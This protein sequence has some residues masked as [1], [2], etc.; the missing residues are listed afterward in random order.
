MRRL[1]GLLAGAAFALSAVVAGAASA[2][3]GPDP[4]GQPA[5][6]SEASFMGDATPTETAAR[7]RDLLQLRP[8]QE[9]ALQTFVAALNSAGQ[10]F[11]SRLADTGPMPQTTPERLDR[12][13]RMM[14]QHQ[15][16]FASIAEATRRF[17]GQ[18]DPAQRRAFD[19]LA[20]IGRGLFMLHAMAGMEGADRGPP[21]APPAPPGE[22]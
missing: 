8:A 17:Y 14:A 16:A 6:R 9:S 19:A 7:L 21:G 18:L 10:G 5:P 1:Q 3:P 2:Q 12:I 22:R 20:S 15:A 11:R 4:A 13:Q